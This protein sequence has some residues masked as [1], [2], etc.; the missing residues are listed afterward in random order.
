[1]R[2][3]AWSLVRGRDRGFPADYVDFLDKLESR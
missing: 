3:L 1:M 2:Q